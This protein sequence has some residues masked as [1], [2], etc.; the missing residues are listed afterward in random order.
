MR[1]LDV[2]CGA[3]HHAFALADAGLAVTGV[4]AS[5]AQ[6]LRAASA[7]ERRAQPV[8][9]VHGDMRELP[10][11]GPF[12]LITCLG[13][14]LG[15]V[16]D[17]Q[18]RGA[19]EGLRAVL[20]PGGRLVVQVH[21]RDHVVPLLPVRSWWQ[22]QRCLVL[23]EADLQFL[24]NKLHVHRTIVFEDGRQFD[25]HMHLRAFSLHELARVL[26]A[27]GWKVLEVSGART[28][29]GLFFGAS[30]PDLWVVA[31]A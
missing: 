17:E 27:A 19:L 3:G 29:R 20:A 13:T 26:G 25:H 12:D 6:L 24:T 9:F 18:T 2:G 23:D 28:T 30:S 5:L 4:D 22:G 31:E 21:N 7:N 16:D 10:V 8:T 15:Y 11:D 1:A 14:T